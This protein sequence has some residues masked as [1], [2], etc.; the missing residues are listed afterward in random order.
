MSYGTRYAWHCYTCLDKH[1]VHS[2]F[3]C[4]AIPC[5]CSVECSP[6]RSYMTDC[7]YS[8][9]DQCRWLPESI[10]VTLFPTDTVHDVTQTH[11]VQTS[12]ISRAVSGTCQSA[13]PLDPISTQCDSFDSN[14]TLLSV[15]PTWSMEL[16]SS[17]ICYVPL[18]N[19]WTIV[20]ELYHYSWW[21]A[22]LTHAPRV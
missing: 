9:N 6:Y 11:R 2:L 17:N 12:W 18:R 4:S 8:P 14:N 16:Y 13:H 7:T 3:L 22:L 19:N 5:N 21:P 1:S 15:T 20:L 10:S